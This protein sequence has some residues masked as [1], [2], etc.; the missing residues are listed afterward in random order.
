[1]RKDSRLLLLVAGCLSATATAAA[2]MGPPMETSS[3]LANPRLA[4]EARLAIQERVEAVHA[5]FRASHGGLGPEHFGVQCCQITQIPAAAFTPADGELWRGVNDFPFLGYIYPASGGVLWAPVQLPSGVEI[6]FLDLYYYDS[7]DLNSIAAHLKAFSGGG[8]SSGAPDATHLA[9]AT[10]PAGSPGY[11]Y[12]T[13][14]AF[15]YTVNN[16]VG[17][18]PAAAELAVMILASGQ[19]SGFRF[20]A[21]DLWWMRQVRPAPS[22]A[23]FNDV[24]T[25]H[26]YFQFVEA[27]AA[28]GITGG[29]G[30]SPPLYCVD[31]PIT[32]GQMAVFL[33]KALGLYW[34]H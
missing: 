19:G 27:I 6:V 15:S 7:E 25:S 29:C 34:P 22:T 31:A 28:A 14:Q 30:G 12:A 10:S 9:T 24:P 20:K 21:V 18:D 32:R 2:H 1:M 13:S 23:S 3:L 5:M 33:S 17:Y 8:V 4:P 16:N 26:P 11:G